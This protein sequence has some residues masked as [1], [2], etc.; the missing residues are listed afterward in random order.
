MVNGRW[1]NNPSPF[2]NVG[3]SSPYRWRTWI[4]GNLP[5]FLINF[6]IAEKGKDCQL[7]NGEHHWYNVDDQSSGCITAESSGSADSGK[8]HSDGIRHSHGWRCL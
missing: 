8:A 4:R 1:R 7:V 6:G 3:C 5:W 2:F